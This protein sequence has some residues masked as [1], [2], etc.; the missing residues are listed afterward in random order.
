MN[1]TISTLG[2]FKNGGIAQIV[3]PFMQCIHPLLNC[4]HPLLNRTHPRPDCTHPLSNSTLCPFL[5]TVTMP[6]WYESSSYAD[7]FSIPEFAQ[8]REVFLRAGWG[9]FLAH[10]QGHDDDIF[11]CNSPSDLMER[12]RVGS[13]TFVVSEESISSATKLPRVGDHGLNTTSCHERAITGSSNLSFRISLELRDTPRSGLK[14][15]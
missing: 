7:L 2:A 10:L 13:L 3:I 8:C 6:K 5:H 1:A 11:L 4:V 15:S 9:S 12:W 14:M